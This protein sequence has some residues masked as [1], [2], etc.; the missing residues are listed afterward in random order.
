VKVPGRYEWIVDSIRARR[1]TEAG[2]A[3]LVILWLVAFLAHRGLPLEEA[4][5]SVLEAFCQRASLNR[6]DASITAS[7][8]RCATFM[9]NFTR[10]TGSD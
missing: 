8:S 9:R 7:S 1:P 4:D 10:E 3:R 2:Q 6:T 5:G